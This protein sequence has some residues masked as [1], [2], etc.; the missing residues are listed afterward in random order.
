MAL[1]LRHQPSDATFPVKI[2]MGT[3]FALSFPDI[4]LL[5]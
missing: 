1:E 5:Y 4:S 3:S 2:L